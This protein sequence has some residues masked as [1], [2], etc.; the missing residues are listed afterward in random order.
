MCNCAQSITN[1]IS[2]YI[3]K[4]IMP[5]CFLKWC[6]TVWTLKAE[7]NAQGYR[8]V[9]S[10][11]STALNHLQ[12]CKLV[13]EY[14]QSTVD[15]D[16]APKLASGDSRNSP[17]NHCHRKENWQYTDATAGPI[18]LLPLS[19]PSILPASHHWLWTLIIQTSHQIMDR[20]GQLYPNHPH[21]NTPPSIVLHHLN[22]DHLTVILM[23]R[24]GETLF[25]DSID[26]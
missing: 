22:L 14:V 26:H 20:A 15:E 8:W 5:I 16:R 6:I 21:F 12:A 10:T 19:M 17:T 9:A 23:L 3:Y 1:R 2:L 11:T 7:S 25:R 13:S 18:G 24:H 4:S